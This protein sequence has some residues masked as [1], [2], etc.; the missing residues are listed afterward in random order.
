MTIVTILDWD[1]TLLPS[2]YLYKKC[3][4]NVFDIPREDIYKEFSEVENDIYELLDKVLNL[5]C[6]VIITNSQHGW[7]QLTCQKFFP[8]VVPLLEKTMIISARDKWENEFP[9]L[10]YLWKWNVFYDLFF[11][12]PHDNIHIFSIGD[13]NIEKD[14]AK[15]ISEVNEYTYKTLKLTEYPSFEVYKHQLKKIIEFIHQRNDCRLNE[16]H[17]YKDGEFILE[18]VFTMN[19]LYGYMEN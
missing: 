7:V 14:C 8:K 1:D 9:N 16:D 12:F 18:T 15:K 19:F 5:G 17:I 13:S 10:S 2:S 4:D 3:K 6:V 11:K